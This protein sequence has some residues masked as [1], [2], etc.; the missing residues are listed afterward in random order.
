MHELSMAEGLVTQL[1]AVVQREGATRITSIVLELGAMC[2][3]EREPF[4]FAFPLVA[5][6]TAAEGAALE[7]VEVPV[8]VRCNDCNAKSSSE[9]PTFLC[10]SCDSTQVEV[11]MGT[12][13]KVKSMEVC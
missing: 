11:Q 1:C 12:D 10:A 4:A 2:G 6:G 5:K 8:T 3:V 9:Y 7:F 13:F